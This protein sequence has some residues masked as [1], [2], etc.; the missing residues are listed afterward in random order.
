[1]QRTTTDEAKELTKKIYEAIRYSDPM[2]NDAL[3]SGETAI[4]I[5]F[6]EFEEAIVTNNYAG[7]I[8]NELLIL[9]N[10][11]NQKCKLLNK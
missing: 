5:K 6:K 3:A 2:S 9:I 8:A 10:D 1:M 11:R 7:N 4:T